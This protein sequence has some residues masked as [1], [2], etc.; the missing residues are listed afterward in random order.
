MSTFD[1]Q[2]MGIGCVGKLGHLFG[3]LRHYQVLAN[4][5]RSIDFHYNF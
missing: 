2:T 1:N 3:F 4:P 5:W